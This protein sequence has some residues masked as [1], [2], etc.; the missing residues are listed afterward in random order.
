[1][2]INYNPPLRGRA[3][4]QPCR[5]RRNKEWSLASEAH[6]PP[7][8]NAICEIGS[9]QEL[10]PAGICNRRGAESRAASGTAEAAP[11]HY[12][13]YYETSPATSSSLLTTYPVGENVGVS[14][15]DAGDCNRQLLVRVNLQ[16]ITVGAQSAGPFY[17]RGGGLNRQEDDLCWQPQSTNLRGCFKTGHHRHADVGDDKVGLQRLRGFHQFPPF[18]TAPTI[19]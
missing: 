12:T 19:S 9:S 8:Q 3:R 4:L 11:F 10:D 1:M 6:A 18:S 2:V 13:A 15:E 16:D 7:S 17:I 14:H 5:A